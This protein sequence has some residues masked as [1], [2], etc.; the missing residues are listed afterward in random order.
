MTEAE[1]KARDDM[2]AYVDRLEAKLKYLGD[3]VDACKDLIH[4]VGQLPAAQTH[5]DQELKKAYSRADN[6]FRD[7]W[8]R[9]SDSARDDQ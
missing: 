9:T 8:L 6:F 2:L 5:T 3:M 1:T 4:C 7:E